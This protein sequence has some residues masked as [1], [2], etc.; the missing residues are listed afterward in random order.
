V[1]AEL[2]VP[3]GL[4]VKLGTADV[5]SALLAAGIG[6]K[7]LLHIVGTTQVLAALTERPTPDPRRLTRLLGVGKKFVQVAFNP[8]GPLALD[9]LHQLCFR[10]QTREEFFQRTIPQ[11]SG[12]PTR[13]SLDPPFLD[14]ERLEIE[15][16]RAA[17]RDLT[18]ATDRLDLVAAVLEALRRCQRKALADLGMGSDLARIC[19]TGEG[20]ETVREL[21]LEDAGAALTVLED[22]A[23][24]G[25]ARLFQPDPLTG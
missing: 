15:A 7:D 16:N 20:A 8:V 18:L 3:A 21:L 13:V 17:F 6:P 12:R 1:A 11:A 5:S 10:E 25:V 23:L 14:G 22:A 4:P 9:W 24:R 2:N 19:T